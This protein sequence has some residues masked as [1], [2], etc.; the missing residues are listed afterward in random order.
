MSSI[1]PAACT[2][3]G[4]DSGG[5]A[6]IQ[7]DLKTFT[8]LGIWG[9]SVIT[10]VT[11][12]NTKEVAGFC[13]VPEEMVLLQLEAVLDDFDIRAIKTGM[14]G[15]AGMIRTVARAL[16]PD[17]PLVLDPVMIATSG[18]RLLDEDATGVLLCTLLPRATVVTPNIP[19]ALVL[20]GMKRIESLSEMKEAGRTILDLGPDYV[21]M[22]GGHLSGEEAVDILVGS[23]T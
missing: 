18:S 2:I 23:H 12:Q 8:A 4:S 14:L 7:A 9:T 15:T 16:P 6:G 22:K 21:V 1:P 11:A 10:A 19:E 13:M 3:A 5:G 20:S 17:I